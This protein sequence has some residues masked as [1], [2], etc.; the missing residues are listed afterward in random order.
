[1]GQYILIEF[2]EDASAER[3]CAQIN[4][5]T[6]KGKAFRIAGIF[7]KPPRKR[8]ECIGVDINSISGRGRNDKII[9][10]HGKTGFWYCTKCK[11][12]RKGWQSPRNQI[13]QPGL[14]VDAVHKGLP[15]ESALSLT[16][17]GEL[18]PNYPL[19]TR[20]TPD[21]RPYPTKK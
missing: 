21:D 5:A 6:A 19:L 17:H 4:A 15:K 1:M 18:L 8:C 20:N 7:Q 12:V 14:P 13:D 3:L 16:Q 2:D 10:R 11:R 9:K